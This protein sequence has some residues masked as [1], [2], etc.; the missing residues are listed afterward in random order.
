M[1]RSESV[2]VVGQGIVPCGSLESWLGE[3]ERVRTH[4]SDEGNTERTPSW[5]PQK[6]A[7]LEKAVKGT[8]TLLLDRGAEHKAKRLEDVA[9]CFDRHE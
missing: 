9:I 3:S 4:G 7:R 5:H 2:G 1:G 8:A 6:V